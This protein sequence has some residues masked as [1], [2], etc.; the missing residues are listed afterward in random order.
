[1]PGH[2]DSTTDAESTAQAIA[3]DTNREVSARPAIAA[4]TTWL[5]GSRGCGREEQDVLG[6]IRF[7]SGQLRVP[8]VEDGHHE[9][10]Q[11]NG[12]RHMEP[13]MT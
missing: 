3:L 4:I 1:L 11:G 8:R 5:P 12:A 10:R 13:S 6:R 2:P 9:A 7:G